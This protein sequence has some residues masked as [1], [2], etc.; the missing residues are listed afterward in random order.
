MLADHLQK[1]KKE[2]KNLKKRYKGI[3]KRYRNTKYNNTYHRT[4]KMIPADV[5]IIHILTV[6]KK[7]MIKILNLKLVIM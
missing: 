1:V 6:V 4:I 5:K 3:Q 2:L 7:L